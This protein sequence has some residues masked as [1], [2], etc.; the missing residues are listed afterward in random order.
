MNIIVIAKFMKHVLYAGCYGKPWTYTDHLHWKQPCGLGTVMIPGLGRE[1]GGPKKVSHFPKLTQLP[2]A[3]SGQ[4][5]ALCSW[6][7]CGVLLCPLFILRSL[8]SEQVLLLK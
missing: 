3:S 1:R 2:S 6:P 5:Q 8:Y 7:Q 4:L